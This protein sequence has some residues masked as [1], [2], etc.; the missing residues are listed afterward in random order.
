[1][2][3]LVVVALS[4]LV[5]GVA[6]AVLPLVPGGVLSLAG[7]LL[8]WTQTGAPGPLLLA[9]L[10]G[11]AVLAVVVDW[12]A[13]VLGARASGTDTVTAVVAGAVGF[14]LMLV[15]GPLGLLA[16]VAGTVL[17]AELRASGDVAGSLRR[18][19]VSTVG[20]VASAAMQVLLTAAVLGAV[21]WVQFG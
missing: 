11:L 6:G 3:A 19:A 15:A 12:L 9:A 4:L 20:V 13:G 21:L 17:V 16:G 18:A 7:V 10:A 8:Y 2:D 1:M 14:V 5:A